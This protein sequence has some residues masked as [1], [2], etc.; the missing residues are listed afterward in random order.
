MTYTYDLSI[1]IGM[2][3]FFYFVTN[4]LK[5]VNLFKEERLPYFRKTDFPTFLKEKIATDDNLNQP[6]DTVKIAFLNPYTTL[7]PTTFHL[8]EHNYTYLEHTTELPQSHIILSDTIS[9]LAL[10]NIYGI[11]ATIFQLLRELYPKANFYHNSTALVCAFRQLALQETQPSIYLNVYPHQFQAT[12]FN[13]KK[14]LFYNTFS[15]QTSKDFIYFVLLI[16]DQLKL[17]VEK[18]SLHIAGQLLEDSEIYRLLYKYIR[19]VQF[20][21]RPTAY[22]FGQEFDMLPTHFH[23]DLYSLYTCE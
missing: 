8:K 9:D 14:L 7:V 2:D 4:G 10:Q 20:V 17:D 15:Y 12:V 16:F 5:E 18:T 11:E 6:Y 13:Q 22:Y 1:L 3:R 19:Q 21:Q 23:F